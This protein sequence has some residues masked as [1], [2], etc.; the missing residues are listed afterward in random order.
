MDGIAS[1][2]IGGTTGIQLMLLFLGN[3]LLIVEKNIYSMSRKQ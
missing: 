3:V 2:D 1:L